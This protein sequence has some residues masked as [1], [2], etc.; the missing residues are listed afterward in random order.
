MYLPG[1]APISNACWTSLTFLD[2]ACSEIQRRGLP[3][4]AVEVF[5]CLHSTLKS[6]VY[7]VTSC[8]AERFI[9]NI[10]LD[11]SSCTKGLT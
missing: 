6:I 10:P 11:S 3:S 4:V 7:K 5:T 9:T 2:V 8:R 1:I